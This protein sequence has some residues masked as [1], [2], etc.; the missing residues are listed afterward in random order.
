[1]SKTQASHPLLI[2]WQELRSRLIQCILF[3]LMVFVALLPFSNHCFELLAHPLLNN[4]NTSQSIIAT[5]VT[6]GFWIPIEVCFWLA[7]LISIPFLLWQLWRFILPALKKQERLWFRFYLSSSLG[8]FFIGLAFCYFLVLPVCLHIL[9][10]AAPADVKVMPDIVNYL[11]FCF[12][13]LLAFGIAYQLPLII[14][15]LCQLEI[16]TPA[17]LSAYRR[18]VIIAAFVLGMIIAPDVISQCLL[19]IPVWFLFEAGIALAKFL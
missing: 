12:H 13:V 2:L 10:H 19:A 16:T 4:L 1:M 6:T 3:F 9:I 5:A 14:V 15:L 11:H 18:Y 7:L 8:L 17:Q